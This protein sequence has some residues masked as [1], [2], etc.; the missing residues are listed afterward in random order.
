MFGSSMFT[1]RSVRRRSALVAALAATAIALAGCSSA[2]PSA[3]ETGPVTLQFWTYSLKGADPKAQAVIKQYEKE[4][5]NVTIK[6]SEVGGT[7]DIAAKLLAAD[8]ANT[9]PDVV[10][11]EYRAL[12]SLVLAGVVKDITKDVAPVRKN[13]AENVWALN[14]L[15]GKTY[16]VPQDIGPMMFT[17]RADLFKQYGVEVPKTWADY[18]K[19]A[20]TIHKKNPKAYIASFSASQFEF[21]LAQARQAGAQWWS[22]DGKKWK[23]GF[24]D[25]ASLATADYWEDLVKR[26]LVKVE[27]L[28]T[29]EWNA[30][31]NNGQILSWAAAAWAPSVIYAVA[32]K[33]AGKWESAPLPQWTAGDPAVPFLGGSTYLVPEK[34]KHAAAAAKFAS[35]LG[36]SDEGSKLLLTLDL[37]PGGNAGREATLN[38]APPRLMPEQTDFYKVADQVI[39]DTTLPVTFGPNVTVAENTF[40]D[41]LSKAALDKSSF[42]AV[43]EA[44]QKAVVADLKKSG[45]DV[46]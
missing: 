13:V 25:P 19:A 9:A 36:A 39:K 2:T 6:L 33:T 24:D 1:G 30:Q 3:E 38:A 22:T 15:N 14:S 4:N 18:A 17:Y 41:A 42:R 23:V 5:P 10:Q 8:R 7:P 32:P 44:T 34:S 21:F 16:G 20:E 37:F 43:Y 35:W 29:P 40:G 28:L 11:I 46:E 27:P 12:P 26:D 31:A 45:Y